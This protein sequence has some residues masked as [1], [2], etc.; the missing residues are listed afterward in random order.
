LGRTHGQH[1]RGSLART[2]I[3]RRYPSER[4]RKAKDMKAQLMR[5]EWHA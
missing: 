5:K 2:V 1:H 3:D 4:I